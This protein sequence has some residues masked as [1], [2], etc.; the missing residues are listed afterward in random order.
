[1]RNSSLDKWAKV[2][3]EI[4]VA[5]SSGEG[6]MLSGSWPVQADR[7]K[8]L[9]IVRTA[10]IPALTDQQIVD[11]IVD[12]SK[13]YLNGKET[14]EDAVQAIENKMKLYVNERE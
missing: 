13:D 10:S 9:A 3:S 8:I 6:I 4:S 2:E 5:T 7:D 11:M 14:V 12:G 1:M